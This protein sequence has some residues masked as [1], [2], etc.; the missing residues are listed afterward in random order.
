MY[1]DALV[2]TAKPDHNP[3]SKTLGQ[4]PL[5]HPT[6]FYYLPLK[7][8]LTMENMDQAFPENFVGSSAYDAER[9][10]IMSYGSDL[11]EPLHLNAGTTISAVFLVDLARIGHRSI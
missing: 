6:W 2:A 8:W 11:A 5:V 3:I 10:V 9:R 7:T 4:P 1:A